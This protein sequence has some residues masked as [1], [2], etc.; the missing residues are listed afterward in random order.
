MTIL[1]QKHFKQKFHLKKLFSTNFTHCSALVQDLIITGP[2][3][4]GKNV[5]CLY[6][7]VYFDID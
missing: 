2:F 1:G 4:K 6:G 7:P 5:I 3:K